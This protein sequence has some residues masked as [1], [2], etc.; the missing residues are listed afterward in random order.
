MQEYTLIVAGGSGTR[1]QTT[2]PKQFI[3]VDQYP[4]LIHTILKFHIYSPNIKILLVLP[5]Q[6]F[7]LW[8]ELHEK[9]IPHIAI[10]VVNGG[11][12]RFNSVKN[13]LNAIDAEDGLVAIHDA[14]RPFV[15]NEIIQK[16]FAVAQEKGSAIT[17]IAL[18]DSIRLVE[19]DHS[20]SVDRA[21][22]RII[23]T[24]QT[25][26][27]SL[28]KKAYNQPE[29]STFTDDASVAEQAGFP[30]QLI[31]G[32][33]ENIKITTPEDLWMAEVFLK[34]AL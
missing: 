16:S 15:T 3:I 7:A 22:Y 25:F 32:S 23:Q 10:K 14:V 24:P 5:A 2:L 27:L 18:K 12:S 19:K 9:Y 13:G 8:A 29:D 31:E 4:I 26:D 11:S 17:S 34:K 30:I 21:K 6:Y 1:M 33:Y 20:E 28:I